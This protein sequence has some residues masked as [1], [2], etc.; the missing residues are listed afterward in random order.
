[1]RIGGYDVAREAGRVRPLLGLV[2]QE[3]GL[4]PILSAR[5]N[6]EYF[7]GIQGIAGRER[8][9]RIEEALAIAGLEEYADKPIVAH[10]SGG[11][12]RR[13]NLAAG[14]V[15]RPRLLLLDEP[16]VGVDTQSRNLILENIRRL[17]QDQGMSVLYTTH[18]M[19]E[20]EALCERVAIMDHGRVLACDTVAALVGGHSGTAIEVSLAAPFAGFE[21]ALSAAPGVLGVVAEGAT[22]YTVQ[23]AD[24]ERGL[25]ALVGVAGRGGVTFETLRIV[26]PSLEQVFLSLTGRELRD[27]R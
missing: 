11:M 17:S 24:Q 7:A 14:L 5:E 19:E 10:F 18:Y 6:L 4:Y 27:G 26:P 21:A 3:I 25:A 1:M 20:A 9:Q 2:P 15:H 22:S 16:T 12:C 23:A 8:K 13:L